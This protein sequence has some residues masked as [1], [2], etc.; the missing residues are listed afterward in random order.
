MASLFGDDGVDD[1]FNDNLPMDQDQL[2]SDGEGEKLFADDEENNENAGEPGDEKGVKLEPKKRAVR[3]PRPRLTVDTLRGPRGIQTIEDYYKDVKFKG[4]GHEKTDLDE[5]L[6]RLQHWG[7]RMYPTYTFDDVLN[8]IERLGK[9]KPLQVHMTRYRLGHLKDMRAHEAEAMEEVQDDQLEGGAGDEPFDEFDALLGEQ[10]A[11]S[12]L[13]PPRTPHQRNMSASASS[14]GTNSTLVTPSF[15]RGNAVMSTP[16]SAAGNVAPT[17]D[18]NGAPL[19]SARLNSLD[20]SDYGQPLPPSQPPTPSAKKLSNEQ[21]AR[22]AENRR[23]AQER[24]KAKQQQEN[25]S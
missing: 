25:V 4:R 15:S 3:N 18:R 12:K 19:G 6:R 20:I 23:L 24:L 16:Y 21:M 17:F 10:I 11:M 1:L 7:H 22:I 13:A 8:N 9:K 5:I 2:P 14:S